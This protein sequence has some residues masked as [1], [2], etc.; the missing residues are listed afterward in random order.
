MSAPRAP[1]RPTSVV[2]ASLVAT[3]V[4]AAACGG[5]DGVSAGDA[6]TELSEQMLAPPDARPCLTEQFEAS[7]PARR[8]VDARQ[9][10]TIEQLDALEQVVLACLTPE[11]IADA[12]AQAM[13]SGFGAAPERQE[14]V[15]AAVL[16][17]PREDQAVFASGPI[18]TASFDV[19]GDGELAPAA[20]RV[21]AITQQIASD[22]ALV[23]GSPVPGPDG[24]GTPDETLPT[25][26]PPPTG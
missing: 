8:A 25:D 4:V 9:A 22:C 10:P 5:D 11:M 12:V 18:A 23:P 3:F 26:P 1:R 13:T 15:R 20:E 17:L 16:A 24:A 19:G 14:C 21:A 2:V 6:A 7:E